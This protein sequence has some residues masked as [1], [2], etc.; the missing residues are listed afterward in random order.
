MK[1][2]VPTEPG[3]YWVKYIDESEW[4]IVELEPHD[5]YVWV[6]RTGNEVDLEVKD[7]KDWHG[8]LEPPV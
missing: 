7:F 5:K 1:V 2:E 8:P 4:E 6:F 3:F